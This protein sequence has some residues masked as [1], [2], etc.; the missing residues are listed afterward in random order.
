MTKTIH[1]PW[2]KEVWLELNERYCYKRIYINAG[3]RT[4]YQY[5]NH[6]L[7]T[8]YIAEGTAEVWLENNDG[9][10]EKTIM[11]KGDFFSVRPPKKHRVI[12]I[13]DVILQEASTPEV[14][15][16]IRIED[17]SSRP[18]GKIEHEHMR[19]AFCILTAGL[20]TRMTDLATHINKGL[21]PLDNKALIS[22]L[23]EKTTEDYEIVIALGYKGNMVREYCEAAHPN[24]DFIFVDV[25]KYEGPGAGPAYSILKCKKH[26]RRPFIWT[27]VDTFFNEKLPPLKTNWLG[28]CRTDIPELY[29]TADIEGKSVVRFKNKGKSGHKY[30]F[31]GTAGVLDYLNF[32]KQIDANEGEIVSAYYNIKSYKNMRAEHF[33]WHDAGTIDNYIKIKSLQINGPSK[34][35]SIPKTNGEFLYKINDTFIKLCSDEKFIHGR[36]SRAKNLEGLCPTVDYVGRNLYSYKWIKGETLYECDNPEIWSKFLSFAKKHMWKPILCKSIQNECKKFYYD[37]TNERLELFLSQRDQSFAGNHTVNNCHTRPIKELL[38][39]IN[40]RELFEGIATKV[41]HGDLQFDNVIYG[42]DEKF[43]LLDWRQDFAGTDVGDVYY[44]LAKMYGGLLISYKLM[45]ENGSFSCYRTEEKVTLE[46]K[47]N[48]SL[49]KFINTYERWIKSNNFNLKKIK[50]LTAL[51]FLNMSPLHEKDFGNLLFFKAKE[52]MEQLN[53]N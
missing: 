46:H 27:A 40:T 42:A 11:K 19:P 20:G 22:H 5:H 10:V 50:T 14:D 24:R 25:D 30:A 16:V 38:K 36:V 33:D 7:E 8:N 9:I 53:D 43:Y 48:I 17:D 45:K 23:I 18:D 31:T 37:K 47:N 1:K 26:L 49:D 41:F 13:T 52:T 2:G 35:Y 51:I 32:W 12:A 21:L 6:K 4:S 15:D 28:L 3:S 29:S 34:N 39:T 44:D